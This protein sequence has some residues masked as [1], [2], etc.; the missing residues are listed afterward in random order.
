MRRANSRLTLDV[1]AQTLSP[2]KRGAHRKLVELIQPAAEMASVPLCS[3]A[4]KETGSKCSK[5]WSGL[6]ES[7]RHLN[8][9]N[10]EANGKSGTY[11]A[12]SGTLSSNWSSQK[13]LMFLRLFPRNEEYRSGSDVPTRAR[14]GT[15]LGTA[16]G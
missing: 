5:L 14:V 10:S 8:L 9:G 2:A 4:E 13:R 3:H 12:L 15:L 7:N 11:E 1:Y 16:N 6:S